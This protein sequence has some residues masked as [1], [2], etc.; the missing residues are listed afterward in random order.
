MQK[1]I[2]KSNLQ[3]MGIEAEEVQAK[4]IYKILKKI[5]TENSQILRK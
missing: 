4:G 1:F 2:K 5:I 3:I